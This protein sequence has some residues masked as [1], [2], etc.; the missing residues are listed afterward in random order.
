MQKSKELQKPEWNAQE[1]EQTE[2]ILDGGEEPK[3]SKTT[4]PADT[5]EQEKDIFVEQLKERLYN[6]PPSIDLEQGLKVNEEDNYLPQEEEYDEIEGEALPV[7]PFRRNDK[8]TH[9]KQGTQTT[10]NETFVWKPQENDQNEE[11]NQPHKAKIIYTE[12][13]NKNEPKF[14]LNS[15]SRILEKKDD[16]DTPPPPVEYTLFT[17]NQTPIATKA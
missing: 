14:T 6:T 1:A 5:E 11:T 2:L 9:G 16:D 15:Y 10:S 3:P 4:P 12:H 17:V 8:N 13:V 7:L